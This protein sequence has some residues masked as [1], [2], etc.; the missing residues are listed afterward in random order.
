[1]LAAGGEQVIVKVSLPKTS[2]PDVITASE[3]L[4]QQQT[5]VPAVA[6]EGGHQR[7]RQHHHD[8]A[9]Y[10]EGTGGTGHQAGLWVHVERLQ[11]GPR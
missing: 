4:V 1:M 6:V 5:D 11:G 8:N 3:G 7:Q 9:A 10:G 2:A